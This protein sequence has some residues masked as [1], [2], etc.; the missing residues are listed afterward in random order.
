MWGQL[1]SWEIRTSTAWTF[2]TPQGFYLLSS[3]SRFPNSYLRIVILSGWLANITK[4]RL[5]L[6][7]W[8]VFVIETF[9]WD[10][11][12]PARICCPHFVPWRPWRPWRPT[13]SV[14]LLYFWDANCLP[15]SQPQKLKVW[16]LLLSQIN[17]LLSWVNN[18]QNFHVYA[19]SLNF[20][21]YSELL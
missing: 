19:G 4:F 12:Q 17:P 15:Q 1:F 8:F 18:W 11:N 2:T 9:Y 16:W 10:F 20:L 3:L 5:G 13:S 7:P 6:F 14:S 21:G